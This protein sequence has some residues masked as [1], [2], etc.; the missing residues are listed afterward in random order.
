MKTFKTS[1]LLRK[2]GV[3]KLSRLLTIRVVISFNVNEFGYFRL[4]KE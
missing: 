3:I 1:L 4:T 2:L